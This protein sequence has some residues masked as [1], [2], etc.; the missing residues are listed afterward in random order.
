MKITHRVRRLACQVFLIR[1]MN[2]SSERK[3]KYYQPFNIVICTFQCLH[4]VRV[5]TPGSSELNGSAD[6]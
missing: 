5:H 4:L 2:E 3:K 6:K 1:A